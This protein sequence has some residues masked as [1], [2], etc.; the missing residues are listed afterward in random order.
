VVL[1][2]PIALSRHVLLLTHEEAA[3][4]GL[5]R[6]M[7]PSLNYGAPEGSDY[8]E[9]LSPTW[10]CLLL[11]PDAPLEDHVIKVDT[12]ARPGTPQPYR[13]RRG[14]IILWPKSGLTSKDVFYQIV[15]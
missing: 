10:A 1:P 9:W 14:H 8:Y 15:E 13:K 5:I 3:E 2:K 11:A 6:P 12:L 4:F 7:S